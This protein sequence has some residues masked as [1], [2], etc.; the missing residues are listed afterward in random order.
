MYASVVRN[1]LS[2]PCAEQGA[3]FGRE[4]AVSWPWRVVG[5]SV[6]ALALLLTVVGAA[7]AVV[8]AEDATGPQSAL[9]ISRA[10]TEPAWET[11][12]LAPAAGTTQQAQTNDEFKYVSIRRYAI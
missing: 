4:R 11:R 6:V 10:S 5:R 1:R 7:P 12:S 9:V 3:G 8:S 2:G